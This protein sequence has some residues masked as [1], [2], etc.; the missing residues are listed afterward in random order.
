M[1]EETPTSLPNPTSV[2]PENPAPQPTVQQPE[3]NPQPVVADQPKS[4]AA[5]KAQEVSKKLT[6]F[7]GGLAE[8][9]KNIDV[10]EL[11]E[12]AKQKVNEVKDKAAELN[13]GKTDTTVLAREEVSAEQMKELTAK[14]STQM[15]EEMPLFIQAVLS[16]IAQGEQLVVKAK[17][18]TSGDPVFIALSAKNIYYF[19]KNAEQF[20]VDIYPIASVRGFSILPPRSETAGRMIIST[21]NGE[22]KISSGSLEAYVKTILLYQK[23]SSLMNK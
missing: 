23:I 10:K 16:D 3:A 4:E 5:I 19:T 22:I 2:Q 7:L 11:T 13:A 1:T 6:G 20:L 17:L 9:A 21:S 18:G 14:I 8:K 15:M 12:K